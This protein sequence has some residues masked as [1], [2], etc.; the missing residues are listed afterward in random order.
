MANFSPDT[1]A[2]LE[3]IMANYKSA[4]ANGASQTIIQNII[5]NYYQAQAGERGYA[6]EA[7]EV[8]A[9]TGFNGSVANQNVMNNFTPDQFAVLRPQIMNRL[10][11]EDYNFIVENHGLIPNLTQVAQEHKD[12]FAF[13][14]YR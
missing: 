11:V 12:V 5:I 10:A 7:A 3:V 14:E 1:L 9:G 6:S 2:Q 8:A 4:V 13:L